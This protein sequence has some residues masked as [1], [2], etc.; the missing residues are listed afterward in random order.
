MRNEKILTK[1]FVRE[2]RTLYTIPSK[3][4]N[5]NSNKFPYAENSFC[6][7]VSKSSSSL[8]AIF[9]LF[10]FI[11]FSHWRINTSSSYFSI[12]FAFV[13]VSRIKIFFLL[14]RCLVHASG[15]LFLKLQKRKMFFHSF[16][17][18]IMLCI[19]SVA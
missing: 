4:N 11:Q 2:F 6:F 9:I 17:P 1:I 12:F 16:S 13:F 10:M 14:F 3:D 19:S 18:S 15:K 7:L 8:Y 5:S